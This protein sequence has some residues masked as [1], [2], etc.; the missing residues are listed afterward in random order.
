MTV[1][2]KSVRTEEDGTE[3]EMFLE[4]NFQ[5]LLRGHVYV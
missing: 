4:F 3:M 1:G 5:E 2:G